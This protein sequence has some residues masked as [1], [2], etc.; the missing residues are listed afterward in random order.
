MKLI[1]KQTGIMISIL[2][3]LTII[4][5][6]H[7]AAE[8]QNLAMPTFCMT[9]PPKEGAIITLQPCQSGSLKQQWLVSNN[10][11]QPAMAPSHCLDVHKSTVQP[12]VPTV[13]WRCHG[14]M[15]QKWH[16]NPI[17]GGAQ[18]VNNTVPGMCVGSHFIAGS[19]WQVAVKECNPSDTSQLWVLWG[20]V[21]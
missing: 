1:I 5:T 2:L 7:A 9:T 17:S 11:I 10:G 14:G 13:T 18:L 12:N 8:F 4:H 21:H 20:F 16:L 3:G 19:G 15:S 6:A